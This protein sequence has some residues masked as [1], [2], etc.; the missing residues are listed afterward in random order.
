MLAL[1]KMNTGDVC[2]QLLMKILRAWIQSGCMS[3]GIGEMKREN[4]D[5]YGM[6]MTIIG[7]QKERILMLLSS[8]DNR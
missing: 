4:R 7:L 1:Q 6:G 3:I 5:A 8:D 2:L